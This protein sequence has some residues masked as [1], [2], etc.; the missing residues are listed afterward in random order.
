MKLINSQT[1][2][3]KLANFQSLLITKKS[4]IKTEHFTSKRNL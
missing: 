1:K 4:L 3:E 2:I